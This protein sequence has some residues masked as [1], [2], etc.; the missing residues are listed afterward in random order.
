MGASVGLDVAGGD[1][2]LGSIILIGYVPGVMGVLVGLSDGLLVG[3]SVRGN[4]APWQL[5]SS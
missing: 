1:V 5:E 2:N 3:L 4:M